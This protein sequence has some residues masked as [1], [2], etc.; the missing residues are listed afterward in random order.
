MP[1][2]DASAIYFS[3]PVF[4]AIFGYFLLK[5]KLTIVQIVTGFITIFG[6]L[7]TTKPEFIFGSELELI[8]K[9]RLEGVTLAII[10]A[11]TGALNQISLRKLKTIP[12]AISCTWFAF[13]VV[14]TGLLKL[15]IMNEW[16]WPNSWF[17]WSLL[18]ANGFS[19][20]GEIYF[21][22]LAFKYEKA[23][24]VSLVYSLNIALTF[25]WQLLILSETVELTSIVGVC[26]VF[27][28]I[29]LIAVFKWKSESPKQFD[30]LFSQMFCIKIA[31]K[32]Y[33]QTQ[34]ISKVN[35]FSQNVL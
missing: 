17:T 6:V 20:I 29:V 27:A 16:V 4:V 1:I 14:L 13:T 26:I 3:S 34:N 18:C 32:C 19:F 15:I 12:V 25:V 9:H 21:F 33:E 24:L 7:I 23:G 35:T 5:E 30:K 31:Q 22:T 2:S 28:S 11:I 8:Y 10:A